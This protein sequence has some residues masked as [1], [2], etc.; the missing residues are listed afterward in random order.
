MEAQ[1]RLAELALWAS[2]AAAP[3]LHRALLTGLDHGEKLT[4]KK[5]ITGKLFNKLL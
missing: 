5:K 4:K 1:W 3:V 2:E